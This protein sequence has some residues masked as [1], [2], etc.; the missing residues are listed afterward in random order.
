[1]GTQNERRVKCHLCGEI[2]K[3][4]N[5]LRA[6]NPFAEGGDIVGCPICLQCDEGFSPICDEPGCNRVATSGRPTGNPD[7]PY[8][9]ICFEHSKA[10]SVK[11]EVLAGNS[12]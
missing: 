4:S 2:V 11:I 10:E 6:I 12:Q 3:Q 8:R 5:L 7:A 9:L 1:M